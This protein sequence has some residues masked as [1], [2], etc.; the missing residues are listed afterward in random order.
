MAGRSRWLV[1]T[2][3]G[4]V[5][6]L[7]FFAGRDAEERAL[8]A[9]ARANPRTSA[10]PPSAIEP[11]PVSYRQLAAAE[12]LGLPFA[13]FYEA[14]RSAPAEA[15]KKWTAELA[16]MPEGPRRTAAVSGFYKLLVQFDPEAAVI[17]IG[18]IEDIGM[19][20]LAL[21]SAVNAASGF[22]LPLMA[23]LS[24]SLED[25]LT[26][27]RDYL[28]DVILEWMLIDAPAVARFIDDH[29]EAFE[30]LSRGGRFFTTDQVVSAWAAVDPKATKEWI[31]RKEKWDDSYQIRQAFIE[32]W[33]ENDRAAAVS[34]TLAHVEEPAM[35]AAIGAIVRGLYSDSK[36]EATKFIQSLPENKR[37]DAFKDAFSHLFLLEEE[38]TGDAALT[39]RAIASWMTEFPPAYWAG[40]LTG[41]FTFSAIGRAEML[42][43]IEQLPPGVREAAAAEYAAPIGVSPSEKIMPVLQVADVVLRDQLLRAMVTNLSLGFDEATIAVNTAPISSEQKQRFLQI[44]AAAKAKKIQDQGSEE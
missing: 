16:Q 11:P 21:G 39:P 33:Y 13:D 23:E 2:A 43:W 29:T 25:R 20:K 1:L 24:L 10:S 12:I 9:K 17:A 35:S 28:S 32:G 31:D 18:E 41:P 38:D 19:Q 3:L 15:R 34:Y 8:A 37:P 7:A 5:A 26:G 40:A 44:I 30:D 4:M 27:K 42:P 14:L 22:A 36:D 6:L